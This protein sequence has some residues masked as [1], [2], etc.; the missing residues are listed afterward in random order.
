MKN[1]NYLLFGSLIVLLNS[2][3]SYPI[4]P[5]EGDPIKAGLSENCNFINLS[6]DLEIPTP[7]YP[8]YEGETVPIDIDNNGTND[9][10]FGYYQYSGNQGSNEN[11]DVAALNSEVLIIVD[12]DDPRIFEVGNVIKCD[13]TYSSGN[14]DLYDYD[15][16]YAHA[17]DSREDEIVETGIWK[18]VDRKCIVFKFLVAGEWRLGWIKIGMTD[19]NNKLIVYEYAYSKEAGC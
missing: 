13:D 17:S 4:D 12:E 16:T 3:T 2:C 8:G 9:I 11:F 19:D 10:S 14:Y 6:P 7:E 18:N 5:I 1:L 15:F